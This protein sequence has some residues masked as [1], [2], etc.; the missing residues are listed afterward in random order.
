M[1]TLNQQKSF[2]NNQF[3]NII[4]ETSEILSTHLYNSNNTQLN[5][6]NQSHANK[7]ASK[8]DDV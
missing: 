1:K 4:L 6:S 3:P 5:Q 2:G 8:N 7:N